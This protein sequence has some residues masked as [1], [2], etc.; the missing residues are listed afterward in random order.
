MV[1][2]LPYLYLKANLSVT[3]AQS[4]VSSGTHLTTQIPSHGLGEPLAYGFRHLPRVPFYSV[5]V[6]IMKFYLH[7]RDSNP[8]RCGENQTF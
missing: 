2:T 1:F 4:C 6:N 3:I 5:V 8:D 7:D